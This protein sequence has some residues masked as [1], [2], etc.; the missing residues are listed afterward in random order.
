MN[1]YM[2]DFE[3]V[4]SAGLV[5]IEKLGKGDKVIIFYS[6]NSD[7][8]SFEMHSRIMKSTADIQYCKVKVGGKNALDFQLATALGYIVAK[9]ENEYIFVISNDK[10]FDK[11]HD[12]WNV[13]PE[14]T[15]DCLVYRVQN[16]DKALEYKSANSK[17]NENQEQAAETAPQPEH[18]K[19]TYKKRPDNLTD[20]IL[21][22][23]GENVTPENIHT[24]KN[25]LKI[26]DTKESFHNELA[27]IFKQDATELYKTLRPKYVTLKKLSTAENKTDK[28]HSENKPTLSQE[29][30]R[31]LKDHCSNED[32]SKIRQSIC[33]S[34][35][36]QELYISML[37]IYKKQRGCELYKII[38]PEYNS[39]ISLKETM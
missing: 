14:V 30:T 8:I 9:G 27:K 18:K 6:E 37:R 3:N 20:Y 33:A 23:L 5:G 34:Q 13:Y 39:L 17:A 12:F 15:T 10:G 2:V 31:L 36:K 29:L 32:I 21:E 11:L 1:T 22:L 16:I 38:K 4:K 24:I 35:T 25:C 28:P 19:R 7:T 26:S